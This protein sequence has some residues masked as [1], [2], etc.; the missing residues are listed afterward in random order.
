MSSI[1][2]QAFC[3]ISI[4]L[5]CVNQL[6]YNFVTVK[7]RAGALKL[8][9][10]VGWADLHDDAESRKLANILMSVSSTLFFVSFV[11]GE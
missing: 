7:T 4:E 10:V 8:L 6:L 3:P 2:Y 5:K 1:K 11:F 9:H